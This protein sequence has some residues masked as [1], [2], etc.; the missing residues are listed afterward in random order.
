[1]VVPEAAENY[2][3]KTTSDQKNHVQDNITI[4]MKA[5]NLGYS[6]EWKDINVTSKIPDELD[7][8]PSTI[9]VTLNNGDQV[10]IDASKYNQTTRMLTVRLLKNLS[11][12]EWYWQFRY[13]Y[14]EYENPSR[15]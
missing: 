12:N 1:M 14:S 7:I 3:N 10:A 4:E 13:S 15:S 9:K 11:E 5:H 8:D 2:K 6:S